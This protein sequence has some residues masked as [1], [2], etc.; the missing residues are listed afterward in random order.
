MSVKLAR[1][2]ADLGI[3]S[4]RFDFSGIGDSRS[5]TTSL[6]YV[7]N[8]NNEILEVMQ[9][10]SERFSVER[11]IC[12]GLCSGADAAFEAA[13]NNDRVIG[14]AQIDPYLYRVPSWYFKHYLPRLLKLSV[15]S[16]AIKRVVASRRVETLDNGQ[17][18][19]KSIST[20]VIPSKA[21]VEL[22]YS[23]ILANG[24]HVLVIVTG[25][26]YYLMNALGQFKKMFSGLDWADQLELCYLDEAEHTLPE[27]ESQRKVLKLVGDWALRLAAR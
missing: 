7:E 25:G 20:R 27:A 13:K 18:E 10:L 23:M 24:A 16:N 3:A 9:S 5:R 11:F 8:I 21:E 12:F 15:W 4:Y 14:I 2:L 6:P 22:G 19:T 1:H 26:Q 17:L